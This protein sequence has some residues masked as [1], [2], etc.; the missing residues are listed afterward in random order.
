MEKGTVMRLCPFAWALPP[1]PLSPVSHSR[2]MRCRPLA[3]DVGGGGVAWLCVWA[4]NSTALSV[5][6]GVASTH[7]SPLH[8][9]FHISQT[10]PFLNTMVS[11]PVPYSQ[12][13]MS[14]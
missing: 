7:E 6:K 12:M 11:N 14:S 8:Y 2:G 10:L 13:S 3:R 1:M 5:Q 4:A 9:L